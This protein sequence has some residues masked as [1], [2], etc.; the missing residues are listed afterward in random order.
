MNALRSC[1]ELIVPSAPAHR[2]D[3]EL[4]RQRAWTE[5]GVVCLQVTELGD[6]YLR[7][8]LVNEATRRWGRRMRK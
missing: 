2:A 1:L 4:L 3:L 6:D 7:R 5:Q 8:A